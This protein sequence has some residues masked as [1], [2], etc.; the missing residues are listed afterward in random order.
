[1]K[2]E[3]SL[4][5]NHLFYTSLKTEKLVFSDEA[6]KFH[7][8]AMLG[9]TTQIYGIHADGFCLLDNKVHLLMDTGSTGMTAGA[10]L[11]EC[12]EENYVDYYQQKYR[13]NRILR[14]ESECE[15]ILGDYEAIR[16]LGRL[17]ILPVSCGIAR[18]ADDYWWTSWQTYRNRYIWDFVDSGRPLALLDEDRERAMRQLRKRQQR[19]LLQEKRASL[20]N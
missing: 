12:F 1:M 13:T 14:S 7:F 20:K 17:H 10:I 11:R 9:R 18:R 16:C 4:Y 6:D 8:L 5:P 15:P 2:K 3:R 19:L